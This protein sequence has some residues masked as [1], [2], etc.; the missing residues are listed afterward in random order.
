[1]CHDQGHNTV[2]LVRLEPTVPLSGVEHSTTEPLCSLK[3]VMLENICTGKKIIKNY[4]ACKEL[5]F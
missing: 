1:M 5:K 4:T 3:K 2:T